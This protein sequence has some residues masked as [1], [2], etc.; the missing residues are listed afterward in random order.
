MLIIIIP[1]VMMAKVIMQD[2]IK[3]KVIMLSSMKANVIL[4]SVVAPKKSLGLR[5]NY[6]FQFFLV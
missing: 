3:G 2:V 4:P 1:S 5:S 6:F